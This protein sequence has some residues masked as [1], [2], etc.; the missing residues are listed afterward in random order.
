M[1]HSSRQGIDFSVSALVFGHLNNDTKVW[2]MV[3]PPLNKL[4]HEN[5][6]FDDAS[7]TSVGLVFR[8]GTQNQLQVEFR[9]IN[10]YCKYLP[11]VLELDMKV[12]QWADETNLTLLH[13]IF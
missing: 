2:G 10:T 8:Y 1:I 4:L 6:Y 12:L 5:N 11:V 9:D 7:F 13:D 3:R